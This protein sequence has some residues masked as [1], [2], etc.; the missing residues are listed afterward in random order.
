MLGLMMWLALVSMGDPPSYECDLEVIGIPVSVM[1]HHRLGVGEEEDRA[2]A[3]RMTL[4]LGERVTRLQVL[5]PRYRGE[6]LVSAEDCGEGAIVRLSAEPLP[7]RISFLCAPSR[8][9]ISCSECPGAAAERVYQAEDFPLVPMA[10]FSLEIELL[11]RSPGYRPETVDVR[12]HPGA[13]SVRVEL[14]PL[15]IRSP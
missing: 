14:E 3:R 1:H 5:G 4:T 12:L 11:L 15:R 6:R 8:L 10:S 13:N 2:L 7:A 9:T